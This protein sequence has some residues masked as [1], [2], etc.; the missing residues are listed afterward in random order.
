MHFYVSRLRHA[1]V[2]ELIHR[3]VEVLSV[4]KMER[5]L[6]AGKPLF[7]I[8]DVSDSEMESL[9]LPEIILKDRNDDGQDL[10]HGKINTL[11]A[12]EDGIR[13][14]EK[15]WQ[16]TF[17][18][19]VSPDDSID[20]R[21]VWEPARMQHIS[22]TLASIQ[23]P[24][25]DSSA[26]AAVKRAA[27][28]GILE[29]LDSNPFLYGPHYMSAMECGLR[30]PVFLFC[31][32]M[33]DGLRD[34]DRVR[35]LEA[36]YGHSWLIFERLSL[37]SSLGNHT[38]AE[39]IGL[40]FGGAVFRN[41]AEGKRWL[42]RGWKLLDQEL[43][44]QILADGGP[45]EESLNYH[46]FVLDLYWLAVDFLEMNDL[47]N[48]NSWRPK[49]LK[50]ERFLKVF[51]G[52]SGRVPSIGDSD[53]GY[54][55]AP[56]VHPKRGGSNSVETRESVT[57]FPESGYTVIRDDK[58]GMLLTFDHGPLGMDPLY[59]HGHA[60][61]LS[62]TLSVGGE[63]VIVDSGT[64]R[65]NGVPEWRSYFKGT[66]AHSTVTIDGADQAVQ[67]SGFVWSRPYSS[68]LVRSSMDNGV[69]CVAATHDGYSR[70]AGSIIHKRIVDCRADSL[71]L[72]KDSFSG[73]GF[74]TF[75]LNYHIHPHCTLERNG[76]YWLVRK[77]E[78]EVC[79]MLLGEGEFRTARGETRPP[80]GWYSPAYGLK[81]KSPVLSCKADGEP[82]SVFFVTALSL[83]SA[84][85]ATA[86][87]EEIACRL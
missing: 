28:D 2:P 18:S 60:D 56:G 26:V 64:F 29:W 30:T 66:R 21:S 16:G 40:I 31:L 10:S 48:C 71:V 9:R 65:Y 44:H 1:S 87:L 83:N 85:P 73:K 62:V 7:I 25:P 45:S 67:E 46:R 47:A 42:R 75:E 84:M 63:E 59:N 39:C 86:G 37:Y 43:D 13:K 36:I 52:R 57:T 19:H 77:G 38:I 78:V 3:T 32:R 6:K 5:L 53:D 41:S 8:P 74:H 51:Q 12:D 20:I 58:S 15:A 4:R 50:G 17:F 82:D 23:R 55:V 54:A 49:L 81:V 35:L 80:L 69:A 72:V 33:L 11:N 22:G 61:A 68:G 27:G 34:T 79:I 24:A 70:L 14:W 76:R